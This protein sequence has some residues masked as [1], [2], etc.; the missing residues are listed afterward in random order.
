MI[1]LTNL[2]NAFTSKL[3]KIFT[4]FR[5]SF[6]KKKL[7]KIIGLKVTTMKVGVQMAG[8]CLE[9]KLPCVDS[10]YN[11]HVDPSSFTTLHSRHFTAVNQC[12]VTFLIIQERRLRILNHPSHSIVIQHINT[13][14]WPLTT[15]LLIKRSLIVKI[16]MKTWAII[17]T[18]YQS[19]HHGRVQR[20]VA[21]IQHSLLLYVELYTKWSLQVR[22]GG[23]THRHF[24]LLT[25]LAGWV[26]IFVLKV[27]LLVIV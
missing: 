8:F 24:T 18:Q 20:L 9:V 23:Q 1:F 16:Q 7:K 17:H 13:I 10:V 27:P 4:L 5:A 21:Y 14:W 12:A 26:T 6:I 3:W 19:S 25:Q 15:V 22:E 2:Q 11:E